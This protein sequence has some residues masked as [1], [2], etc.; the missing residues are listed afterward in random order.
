MGAAFVIGDDEAIVID[1][2]VARLTK[3]DLEMGKVLTLYYYSGSNL[4]LVARVLGIG[5]NRVNVLVQAG[6]AWIDA[7]L[8]GK[9]AG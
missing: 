7:K 4:S 8:E 5:R 6:T 3:S 9:V 1:I 2:V